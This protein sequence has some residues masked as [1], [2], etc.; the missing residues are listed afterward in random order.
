M[1]RLRS[2]CLAGERDWILRIDDLENEDQDGDG[3][4]QDSE[5]KGCGE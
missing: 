4:V 3:E 2:G 5:D 1:G